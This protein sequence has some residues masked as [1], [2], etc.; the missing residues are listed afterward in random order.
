MSKLLAFVAAG[1]VIGAG[2]FGFIAPHALAAT[3]S[4][5]PSNQ[6]YQQMQQFM[7]SQ[8]GQEM[9]QQCNQYMQSFNQGGKS[10][11]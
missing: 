6:V 11:N 9:Y 3:H 2:A 4:S 10:G 7:N 8:Q 5:Q 1:V